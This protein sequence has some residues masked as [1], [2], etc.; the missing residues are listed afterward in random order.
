MRPKIRCL[1]N[2]L[3]NFFL[4]M[5]NIPPIAML[6]RAKV[7]GCTRPGKSFGI[8]EAANAATSSED[9][10]LPDTATARTRMPRRKVRRVRMRLR[11]PRQSH[12]NHHPNLPKLPKQMPKNLHHPS[13]SFTIHRGMWCPK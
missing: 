9:A 13:R 6:Q 1:C 5:P 3:G 12:R 10:V 2:V 4:R 8:V 7:K 11:H